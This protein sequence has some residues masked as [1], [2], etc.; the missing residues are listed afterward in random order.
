MRHVLGLHA[1]EEKE[2]LFSFL[3][4]QAK[5]GQPIDEGFL[6]C[7]NCGSVSNVSHVTS[8]SSDSGL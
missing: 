6:T 2:K 4:W 1:L 5:D 7:K 3:R 8:Q